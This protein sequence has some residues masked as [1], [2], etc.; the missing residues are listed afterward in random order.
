MDRGDRGRHGRVGGLVD[1]DV[2]DRLAQDAVREVEDR[3]TQAVVAE[4]CR[5][6]DPGAAAQRQQDAGA[7]TR[8]RR[9]SFLD[10]AGCLHLGDKAGNG[11]A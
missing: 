2:V 7:S 3:D 10:E 6:D 1:V 11:A 9:V 5:D 8:C 4:V